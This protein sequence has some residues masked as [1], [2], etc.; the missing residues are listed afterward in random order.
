MHSVRI[1]V[2]LA[3]GAQ[4]RLQLASLGTLELARA[5][6]T[7]YET[8]PA[9]LTQR[10]NDFR[11]GRSRLQRAGIIGTHTLTHNPHVEQSFGLTLAMIGVASIP[12]SDRNRTAGP[13]APCARRL[14]RR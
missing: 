11:R 6:R 13:A 5:V 7:C 12:S 14:S 9:T 1:N 8:R 2:H 3:N 4:H 10:I